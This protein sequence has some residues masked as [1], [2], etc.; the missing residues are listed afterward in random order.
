MAWNEGVRGASNA[1]ES[2]R[3]RRAVGVILSI[4]ITLNFEYPLNHE[5]GTVSSWW[6]RHQL[7]FAQTELLLVAVITK[8]NGHCEKPCDRMG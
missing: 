2:G 3:S 8:K 5:P 7:H 4:D 1:G 6:K